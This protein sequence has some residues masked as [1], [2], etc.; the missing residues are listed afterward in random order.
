M[1]F[2]PLPA[3]KEKYFLK[4]SN[5]RDFE[6]EMTSALTLCVRRSIQVSGFGCFMQSPCESDNLRGS[7]RV[8]INNL[9]AQW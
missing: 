1:Y 2:M 4:C 7:A 5:D 3:V 8:G 6:M 9:C